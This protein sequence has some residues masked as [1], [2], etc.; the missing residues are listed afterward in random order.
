VKT[1]LGDRVVKDLSF[2]LQNKNHNLYINNYF[3]SLPLLSYFK[4][5]GINACGIINLTRKYLP[6]L[7]LDKNMK[8]GDWQII[9]QDNISIVKFKDKRIV[10]ILSDFH[11][12]QNVTQVKRRSKDGSATM[13]NNCPKFLQ[14]YN[15]YMN[16]IDKSQVVTLIFLFFFY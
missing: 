4:T 15:N 11:D 5:K 1:N 2:P 13:I 9:D 7:F 12:P 10:S 3:I 16:C 14:Y 8:L 6:K